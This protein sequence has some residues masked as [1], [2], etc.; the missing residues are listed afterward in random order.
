M[1]LGETDMIYL[2]HSRTMKIIIYLMEPR[3]RASP[4]HGG[5]VFLNSLFLIRR[6]GDPSGRLWAAGP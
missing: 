4:R 2:V 3:L 1:A 6:G 5:Q